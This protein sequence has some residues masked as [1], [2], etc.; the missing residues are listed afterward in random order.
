MVFDRCQKGAEY[1]ILFENILLSIPLKT[2][3]ITAWQQGARIL[4]LSFNRASDL[5]SHMKVLYRCSMKIKQTLVSII[6]RIRNNSF[7]TVAKFYNML[8]RSYNWNSTANYIVLE[9]NWTVAGNGPQAWCSAVPR[10]SSSPE[11]NI[12]TCFISFYSI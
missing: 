8:E 6:P 7:E 12:N 11:N 1:A 4:V 9:Q 3:V 10:V 2:I 5:T